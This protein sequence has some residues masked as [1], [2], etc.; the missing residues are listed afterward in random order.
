MTGR[1]LIP[2]VGRVEAVDGVELRTVRWPTHDPRGGVVIVHG[3][4]EHADRYAHVARA[5]G[6]SGLEVYA[7]DQ[8]GHG[9]SGGPRGHAN[10]FADLLGDLDAAMA[11]SESAFEGEARFLIGHSL[12]GLVAL[13]WCQ[14]RRPRLDGLVASAPWL[15]TAVPVAWPKLAVAKVAELLTPRLAMDTG[16]RAH[17]LTSDPSVIAAYE[18]DPA[19]HSRITA[20]L[21]AEVVRWQ[22]R[23][24]AS[25]GLLSVDSLF[26]IPGADP[27]ADAAV[28]REFAAALPERRVTVLELPG[29]RHEPFNER[30]RDRV[31]R[32]VTAWM[33][34]RP[35]ASRNA[36]AG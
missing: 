10:R 11:D 28:T 36:P 12:G 5:L 4:G 8:R 21:Y 23:V 26:L 19:V 17:H 25:P 3:L 9:A 32:E 14:S 22:E 24:L 6:E 20:R 2:E 7:Y 18:A 15:A 13:A 1:G 33:S 30:G 35:Q 29:F 16:T 34:A 31:L 27:L